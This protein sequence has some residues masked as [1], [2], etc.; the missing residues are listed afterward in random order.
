LPYAA[1]NEQVRHLGDLLL[2]RVRIG[3]LTPNGGKEFLPRV[4]KLCQPV[5]DW[6]AAKWEQEIADYQAFWEMA[7]GLPEGVKP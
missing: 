2:R 6:D 3:L 7:H 1:K 5:L 4:Q